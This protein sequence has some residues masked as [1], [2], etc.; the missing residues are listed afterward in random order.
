MVL[1][2][3]EAFYIRTSIDLDLA[4]ISSFEKSE[5]SQCQ[6]QAQVAMKRCV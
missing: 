2:N 6:F 5:G 4:R 1:T 3:H